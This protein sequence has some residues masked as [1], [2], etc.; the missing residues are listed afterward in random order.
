MR[1]K[2]VYEFLEYILPQKSANTKVKTQ[3]DKLK[4]WS[5]PC[6]KSFIDQTSSRVIFT[7][8]NGDLQATDL[9]NLS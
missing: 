3:S 5:M 1:M 4:A 7:W 6:D 9:S 8:V 2:N